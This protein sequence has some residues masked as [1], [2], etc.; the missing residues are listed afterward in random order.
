MYLSHFGLKEYPFGLTP[1]TEYFF[2]GHSHQEVLNTLLVSLDLGEGLIKILGEPGTGKTLL[3]R[4]LLNRLEADGWVAAYIPNPQ[5]TPEALHVALLHELGE[6]GRDLGEE[7]SRAQVLEARLL[8]LAGRG[9]RIAAL[10]DETQAMPLETLEALR[11]ITNLETEK[12]KLMQI[13]L[14]GQPELDARLADPSVRQIASRITFHDRLRP[15]EPAETPR[16]LAH[17]LAQ[18][19]APTDLFST[20]AAACVH[21]MSRGLPRIANIIAHKALML[22][23]GQSAH[24]VERTHVRA[25]GLDTANARLGALDRLAALA[26]GM[27]RPRGRGW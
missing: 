6:A 23:F 9:K 3:C 20:P 13:V 27:N 22:A 2:P 8:E 15:M 16:Y 4:H 24:R 1:D 14:F 10:I 25:A 19:G 5:L 17:R 21:R 7:A 18:A 12:R 11:L 26:M